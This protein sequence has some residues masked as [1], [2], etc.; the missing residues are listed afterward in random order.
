MSSNTYKDNSEGNNVKET[1]PSSPSPEA[2]TNNNNNTSLSS[3]SMM[4]SPSSSLSASSTS[5]QKSISNNELSPSSSPQNNLIDSNEKSS[6]NITSNNNNNNNSNKKLSSFNINDL[7]SNNSDKTT[8]L[9]LNTSSDNSQDD[10][11]NKHSPFHQTNK[12]Q[13][14]NSTESK[15]ASQTSGSRSTTPNLKKIQPPTTNNFQDAFLNQQSL[16]PY[17]FLNGGLPPMDLFTAEKL[18]QQF[19]HHQHP[20]FNAPNPF[21]ANPA[22]S[23]EQFLIQHHSLNALLGGGQQLGSQQPSLPTP[24]PQAFLTNEFLLAKGLHDNSRKLNESNGMKSF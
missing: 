21:L 20:Q 5:N 17:S 4:L 18:L 9:H 22:A 24:P 13:K 19:H 2:S 7:L 6:N 8:Q 15:S 16:N 11:N 12:R 3:N 10:P 14:L 23:I 1:A